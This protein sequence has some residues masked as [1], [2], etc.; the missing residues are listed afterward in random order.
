LKDSLAESLQLIQTRWRVEYTIMTFK[1]SLCLQKFSVRAKVL[2][3][4]FKRGHYV[5]FSEMIFRK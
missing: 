4:G 1:E 2:I 3:A 5:I